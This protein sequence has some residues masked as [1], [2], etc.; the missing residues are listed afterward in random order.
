MA[1]SF[2]Q[3]SGIFHLTAGNTSYIMRLTAEQDLL[4]LYWGKAVK[5]GNISHIYR[6]SLR[7]FSPN[8]HPDNPDMCYDTLPMEYPFYGS[9]DFRTPAF[10]LRLA[11]GSNIV[12]PKYSSHRII[13]GKPALEGLPATYVESDHEAQ[14]LEIDLIDELAGIKVILSYSAFSE[15]DI[16]ARSA[17][18]ENIGRQSVQLES[19]LSLSV[20]FNHS[21]FEMLQL[22]GSWARERHVHRR[23]L[24]PGI[25]A[26]DSKRGSSSHMQNPF[27]ALLSPEAT[28]ECG[29][30]YG[31]AFVYSG[32][33]LAQAEVDQFYAT[34]ISMGINPFGFSW[35]LQPGAGF[36]TPEA[37]MAYSDAG[38]NGMSQGLHKIM[39]QRLCRGR[40][41]DCV[42]PVL[43]NN[44]EATYF[45]FNEEKLLQIA[46]SAKELGFEQF[47]LD[48]GWFG[49][50]NDDNCSL[51]DWQVNTDK[52]PE[53]LGGLSDKIN[54][55]GLKF[56]LWVE[57]EMISKNSDLYRTHPDWCLHVPGRRQSESRQQLVLDLARDEVAD[58]LIETLSAVF[59]SANVEYVK[60]DMNRN[61]TECFSIAYPA[62]QQG[63]ILH[64][65]MLNLYRVMEALNQN[66]PDILFESCS[67]GG[68]RYDAG[69]LYYMPQTWASDDTDA[70]ERLKIQWGTSI[71]YPIS[72]M[73]THV[74]DIPNHQILRN[75]P[76]L[77][78]LNCAMGGNM[79]CEMD[80]SKMS[81]GDKAFMKAN[82]AIYKQM[83]ELVQ[84]GQFSR[85]W[86]PFE[87]NWAAWQIVSD[88]RNEAT[89]F[90]CRVLAEPHEQHR[91]IKLK[92]LDPDKIYHLTNYDILYEVLGYHETYPGDVLMN[93]GFRL[94]PMVGDFQSCL[95]RFE[96]V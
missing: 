17:R 92:N 89:L 68:G 34:R 22:S 42:R 93:V 65:Y 11:D 9:G 96:A 26:I 21:N 37:M 58:W 56:G 2:D 72:S 4:H 95:I 25:T 82:I 5:D 7:A 62:E 71:A 74:S 46:E 55:L 54:A 69:M 53:G 39:R 49:V 88:D 18:I 20:N 57:P 83:R 70:I 27:L 38:L 32:S 16:I 63:E 87:G 3:E 33:F 36:Q 28:E 43:I 67:G 44:W 30:T 24:E 6:P 66:F 75:T 81:D 64:R 41:R 73:C 52:L 84:F 78:R 61:I 94:T 12:E 31:L 51:G 45:D 1:I 79:G 13:E 29:D 23:K 40:F 90:Y 76:I 77:T 35:Q 86:N 50:R 60:W 10:Q 47:V 19:A 80:L 91:V 85:L 14:T 15:H 59:A 8:S 48:D